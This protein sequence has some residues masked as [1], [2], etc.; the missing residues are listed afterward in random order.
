[1]PGAGD[2]PENK[3]GADQHDD[4]ENFETFRS[5]GTE[6][7]NRK[8]KN[9][10]DIKN[11]AADDVAD[12]KL[13]FTTFSGFDGGNKFRKRSTEGNDGECDDAIGDADGASDSRGGINN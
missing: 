4:V 7:C 1:M 2:E 6:K 10:T 5:D 3:S 8:P 12:E 11:V 9:D 13:S